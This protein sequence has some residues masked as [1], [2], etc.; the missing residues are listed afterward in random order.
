MPGLNKPYV[1]A[2]LGL[3]VLS[4]GILGGCMIGP[5][6]IGH[7]A[8]GGSGMMGGSGTMGSGSATAAPRGDMASELAMLELSPDQQSRIGQ[9]QQEALQK[10]L[11]LRQ[12]I[13][14]EQQKLRQLLLQDKPDPKAVGEAYDKVAQLQRQLIQSRVEAQNRIEVLLTPEQ[15]HQFQQNR[16]RMM[17]PYYAPG[18]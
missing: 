9:I 4:A 2:T 5:G 8:I 14:N 17:Q 7:G 1:S 13:G 18:Q 15:R 6:M 3:I 10:D 12:Q 16:R 11:G